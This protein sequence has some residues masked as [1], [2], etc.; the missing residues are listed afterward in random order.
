MIPRR[1]PLDEIKRCGL[2]CSKS[3]AC[4]EG[5]ERR[6]AIVLSHVVDHDAGAHEQRSPARTT[7]AARH[8]TEAVKEI[9][10]KALLGQDLKISRLPVDE[11]DVAKTLVGYAKSPIQ[12]RNKQ[13]QF[14]G[15]IHQPH[16]R[17]GS[18][19]LQADAAAGLNQ[20]STTAEYFGLYEDSVRRCGKGGNAQGSKARRPACNLA[21]PLQSVR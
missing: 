16:P 21:R 8:T 13:G 18:S 20:F 10:L 14:E 9:R 2:Y 6:E 19:Y 5:T 1:A 7:I 11:L 12:C 3:R 4:R 17:T 15:R